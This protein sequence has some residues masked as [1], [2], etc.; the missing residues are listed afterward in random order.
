MLRDEVVYDVNLS[1][2]ISV[3]NL[4]FRFGKLVA[5][6]RTIRVTYYH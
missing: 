5:M 4:A 6:P 2:I 3:K 1:L